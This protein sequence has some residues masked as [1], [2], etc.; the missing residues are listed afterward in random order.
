MAATSA[1]TASAGAC[2]AWAGSPAAGVDGVAGAWAGGASCLQPASSTASP[3][4]SASAP[5]GRRGGTLRPA[6]VVLVDIRF[7]PVVTVVLRI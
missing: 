2:G 7:S 6:A 1:E 3:S 4:P 5:V